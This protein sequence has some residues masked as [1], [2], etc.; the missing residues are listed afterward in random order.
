MGALIPFPEGSETFVDVRGD[1]RSMRVTRHDES[2]VVVVS[3][4]VGKL[5]RASF[6]L[7]TDELPRLAALLEAPA[8]A[9]DSGPDEASS[10]GAAEFVA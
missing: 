4:W 5:C 8:V 9:V 1:E 3:L 6:R 2:G 10:A 7:P